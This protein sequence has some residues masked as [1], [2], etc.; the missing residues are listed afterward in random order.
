MIRRV[1]MLIAKDFHVARKES[2]ISYMVLA[3]LLLAL[4]MSLYLPL[5][6]NMQ[7][8]FAVSKDVR[9]ALINNLEEYGQVTVFP[10]RDRVIER[11]MGMDDVPGIVPG[12][13][14]VEIILEGNE[15]GYVQELPG[16][17]ADYLIRGEPVAQVQKE[18]LGLEKTPARQYLAVLT[19]FSVI[20]IGG[21]VVGF[22]IIEEKESKTLLSYAVSPLGIAEYLLGKSLLASILSL[23]L[24]YATAFIL[25][26]RQVDYTSLFWVVLAALPTGLVLGYLMGTY[27]DNQLSAVA[28]LK[29]LFLL[30][31]GLPIGSWFVGSQWEFVFYPFLNY[32]VVKSLVALLVQ[33]DGKFWTYSGWAL[34]TS[35]IP[36]LFLL[37]QMRR[38]LNL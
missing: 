19:I 13:R 9:P 17:L 27:A 32:W 3:P 5:M 15:A 18:S 30:F 11:V 31:L 35:A 36:L 33:G 26:G 12:P 10:D 1:L 38:R 34:V 28:L 8:Q 24:A 4:L 22:T 6:E 16:V 14:G 2:I 23:L 20:L 25:L 29:V 37:G 7:L 21:M